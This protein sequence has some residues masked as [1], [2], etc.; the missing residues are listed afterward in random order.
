MAVRVTSFMSLVT[1]DL[2]HTCEHWI[3]TWM[4]MLLV[5]VSKLTK[6]ANVL[7]TNFTWWTFNAM[8]IL[9]WGPGAE[10]LRFEISCRPTYCWHFLLYFR[11]PHL[12]RSQNFVYVK[13]IRPSSWNG[14]SLPAI[15]IIFIIITCSPKNADS[16][17]LPS[18]SNNI[19]CL[20]LTT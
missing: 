19:L 3:I 2:F 11:F 9:V 12:W 4:F 17:F 20:L 7:E 10:G 6:K 1:D 13:N 15:I 5:L 8:N 16:Y 14:S 18:I